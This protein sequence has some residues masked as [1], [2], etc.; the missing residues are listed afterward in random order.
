MAQSCVVKAEELVADLNEK[1]APSEII[2][3]AESVLA[4]IQKWYGEEGMEEEEYKGMDSKGKEKMLRKKGM[5]IS[6][7]D[8]GREEV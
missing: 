6:I 4:D 5:M 7:Q 8:L 1:N 2:E 3:K